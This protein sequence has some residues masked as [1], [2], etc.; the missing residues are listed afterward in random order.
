MRAHRSLQ[1]SDEPTRREF[2]S[3]A[4]RTLLGVSIL[5][6]SVGAARAEATAKATA[7]RVIY[8][9]MTGG[10]SQ[11]DTF[12]P[13]PE[14]KEIQGSTTVI[15]T[16]ADGIRIASSLPR[17]AKQMHRVAVIESMNSNQGA[18][19]QGVYYLHTNY[20]MRGT[21]QHPG[22]GAWVSCLA[23][24]ANPTLP[25]SV[26]INGGS[27]IFGA[28]YMESKFAPL[29]IGDPSAGLRNSRLAR[30]VTEPVFQ[31]RLD[32]AQKMNS[33]FLSRTD[34][35]KT[36]S[37]RDVYDEALALMKS[38]DLKAF[39]ITEESSSTRQNYGD[40]AF[41][42]G[43]LLARRLAEHDIRFIEVNLGNWDTHQ[44]NFNRVPDLAADL[45]QGMGALL[46]DLAT[47]GMLEDTLVVLATEFGRTPDINGGDG[48]DH[49]PKAF[50]CLMA[51]GGVKGG[52]IYGKT[53]AEGR[54]I[55]ENKV[56]V[57]DFNATIGQALGLPVA[58][59]IFAPNGRPFTMANKGTPIAIF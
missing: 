20:T 56:E 36:R 15:P 10:M 9:F 23:E 44:D 21:I 28:G 51:G 37:Y 34:N 53:D 41:G 57:P 47:R 38:D 2:L 16:S 7:K 26:V 32:L 27:R 22:L 8:L 45:D 58:Q 5:P 29:P 46:E 39:D 30:G 1:T 24:K 59:E 17:M 54:E 4:A 50:T 43:C 33:S 18:H 31:R 3:H 48:R 49:Y 42:Q 55:A 12:S 35:R 11:L 14:A 52:Q 40:S 6:L 25:S 13:K 19:E